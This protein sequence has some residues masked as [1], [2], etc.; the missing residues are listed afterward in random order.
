MLFFMYKIILLFLL[1]CFLIC[2]DVFD[3]QAVYSSPDGLFDESLIRDISLDFYDSDYN[4]F[5]IQSWF[6]N[7]KLRRAA[8]FEMNGVYFD[9]VAV[10]Y[11]GNSTFYVPWSVNNPKLPFNIDF[12]EYNGAQSV[13]GYE[14]IKLA[15][16]LFDPTMRKEITG[17][18]VYRQYLPASQANFMNLRVNDEFL[19][20]YVNTESVNLEFMDKHFNEN[21]GVFFKCEPQDLF[22]VEN[23]SLVAALDYRGADSLAYYESYELKSEKGWKELVDM[24]YT[25][26]ND[27]DNIEKYLNVDRVLWYLAVNTA[28]LNTDTYS[29]V[30]IRNYYLYQTNNGQ[31]QIIPWDVSESFIGALF[32][33]WDDPVNLYEASPYYGF[34]PY[35]ESRPLVYSL[36]SVDRYRQNY[37]A[38]L[39]TIISQVVNTSFIENRVNELG[40]LAAEVDDFD[41]NTFF[42]D[43]F[44]TNVS[45][46]YWFF[47]GTWNTFGGI[48][49]TLEERSDYLNNHPLMNVSVPDIEYVSQNIASPNP[50]DE[51]VVTTKITNVNQ[52]ELMLT[53]QSDHFNFVSYP[54]NDDGVD[55]DL[56]AGDDVY[57]FIIPFSSSGDYVQ[58]YIRAGNSEGVSLSPEKAEFEF[59]VYTVNYEI[60]TSDIVINEIMAV[61]DNAVAD[62]FGEF[63]DWIELYNKGNEPVDLSNYHLSDDITNLGKYVFPSV[64]LAP[65]EYLIIWA[66]DDEEDQ[67]DFHATFNLSSSG[68]ELYLSDPNFNIID[69]FVFGQQE[70]DMA[71]ARVP[72]GVGDF[73]IQGSTFFA[74]NDQSTSVSDMMLKEKRLIK[75]TDLIGREV[76]GG[77]SG[78]PLLYIYDDGSVVKSYTF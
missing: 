58:Y 74:N 28:I 10:R 51:V 25:L 16:A 52:V 75:I 68:E 65:D 56:I 40:G 39:R 43:G 53:S 44:E 27:I 35:E 42:G 78:H 67:G 3:S 11:K 18:S 64:T 57:S 26:N 41:E 59:Y 76:T 23:N 32:W 77:I 9:S 7:T 31:F 37:D 45:E 55:G 50:G 19:G 24:I 4:E 8:S 21:D 70:V 34:D 1:P 63:D 54:M 13:L 72:N 22:G 17:F 61:N 29:L 14:K 48:L 5:L 33:W 69:G 20:L 60:L 49:N 66:D 30:N 38:H 73:I 2:Q 71:Y 47:N 15:N 36:L 46:D 12:N 62:E 6:D